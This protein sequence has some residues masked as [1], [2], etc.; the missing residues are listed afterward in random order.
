MNFKVTE[1]FQITL[2]SQFNHHF[3]KLIAYTALILNSKLQEFILLPCFIKN[4]DLRLLSLNVRWIFWQ[5]KSGSRPWVMLCIVQ[6]GR[7]IAAR[8]SYSLFQ[9][10]GP[11]EACN[12]PSNVT[13]AF[14][15][16]AEGKL[17][18]DVDF[19][20]LKPWASSF[21]GKTKTNADLVSPEGFTAV[22]TRVRL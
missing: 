15:L 6:C 22:I 4:L 17:K 8:G 12:V 16:A 7:K 10:P 2:A 1:Q 19:L 21:L 5:H 3:F 13:L 18:D 9:S 14:K 11:N 20:V